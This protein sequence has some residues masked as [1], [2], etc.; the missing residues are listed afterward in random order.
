M[1]QG[2]HKDGSVIEHLEELRWAI[3]RSLLSVVL[4]FPV[5]FYFS[6]QLTGILVGKLCPAGLKLRYFSPVEPFLVQLKISLFIAVCVAAPY[7][8]RQAWGFIAPGLYFTEKR[9][10]GLLLV[11]SCALFAA[12]AAF[13]LVVILP[14]VMAFSIGFQTS[15]LEAAIGFEQ[16]I[17][18]T[19]MLTVA[20]GAMF[21]CPAVVFIL[22][23]TGVVSIERITA[24]RSVIIVVILVVSAILTPPDVFSQ[25]MMAIPTWLLFE[26][27]LL[28]ARLFAPP[29]P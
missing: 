15:Y 7:I 6:D 24:L 22:I 1:L 8:L 14:M 9:F 23:R 10:A 12:G 26:L 28:A 16:F 11:I 2:E 17:N 13:S 5:A 25:L 20:F 3:I 27:G 19:G 18:L 4:L 21:Q 29:R